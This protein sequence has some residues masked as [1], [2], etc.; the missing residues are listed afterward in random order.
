MGR[1]GLLLLWLKI[2]A[3]HKAA[4]GKKLDQ[5]LPTLPIPLASDRDAAKDLID[6]DGGSSG[7]RD[8]SQEDSAYNVGENSAGK[9]LL[10]DKNAAIDE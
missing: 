3:I 6:C 4:D 5:K 8:E 7:D 9:N 10:N 1:L 2:Q